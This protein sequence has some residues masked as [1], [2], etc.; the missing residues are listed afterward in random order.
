M[1][2][3][4]YRGVEKEKKS[5]RQHNLGPRCPVQCL[6]SVKLS[7]E[8]KDLILQHFFHRYSVFWTW[9]GSYLKEPLM[10]IS[11]DFLQ[12][13]TC[14]AVYKPQ[15]WMQ[16][17]SLYSSVQRS[18]WVL[19]WLLLKQND[20]NNQGWKENNSTI[21][22]SRKILRYEKHLCA[23][24]DP[25]IV[26]NRSAISK[27][28]ENIRYGGNSHDVCLMTHKANIVRMFTLKNR[29][30]QRID[31]ILTQTGEPGGVRME[32]RKAQ[33]NKQWTRPRMKA[34]LCWCSS[35]EQVQL[36]IRISPKN[37]YINTS[38]KL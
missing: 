15:I 2:T 9:S 5:D 26:Q 10:W 16:H 31:S 3:A 33:D 36:W 23:T 19:S 18:K 27:I 20:I 1:Y 37:H 6:C 28:C 24:Y 7:T 4:S 29:L 25:P 17:S 8:G 12:C 34:K 38:N 35:Q 11:T 14:P 22:F 30:L 21:F 32:A 13:F